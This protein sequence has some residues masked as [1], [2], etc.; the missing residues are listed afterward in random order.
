MMNDND[1]KSI[2]VIDSGIGGMTVVKAIREINNAI[3]VAY[4]SDSAFFPYGGLESRVLTDR[5]H[6]LVD[7]ALDR[8]SLDAVVIA[9]N[10]AS[11]VVLDNL[12]AAFSVPF[13]GVVPP[14][15]TAG[16]ISRSRII[17]L[18][19]TEG[20][21]RRAYIDALINDFAPDCQ[22][23]RVEC[24]DLAPMAEDKVRGLPVDRTRLRAALSACRVP[25]LSDMDVVILGCT[26]YPILRTEIADELSDG[27]EL[28]DPAMPVARQL[29]R[30]LDIEHGRARRR[31]TNSDQFFFTDDENSFNSMRLFLAEAGF[32]ESG[33]W[34]AR[35]LLAGSDD[36]TGADQ[37]YARSPVQNLYRTRGPE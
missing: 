33:Y 18:L 20:T 37:Y 12:R 26:H 27:I 24:P 3:S 25:A 1:H 23:V 2:L 10:T 11:T 13:V 19:A 6:T 22:V 15:K 16:E 4:I 29:M 14:V 32:S 36:G 34:N 17:G 30:V 8:F 21:V 7:Q 28:L 31:Q 5:L 9:C 35:S